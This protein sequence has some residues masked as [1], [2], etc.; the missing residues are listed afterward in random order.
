MLKSLRSEKIIIKHSI[1]GRLRVKVPALKESA[2]YRQNWLS[3]CEK[4][5]GMGEVRSNMRCLSTVLLYDTTVLNAEELFSELERILTGIMDGVDLKTSEE[6]SS[7]RSLEENSSESWRFGALSILAAGAFVCKTIFKM[8]LGES[9]FTPLGAAVALFTLPL[10]SKAVKDTIDK[11]RINLHTFLGGSCLLAVFMGEALTALEILWITEGADLLKRIITEKSRS[12]IRNILEVAENEVFILKDG[13]EVAVTSSSLEVGEIIVLHTGEKIPVDATVVSGRALVNESAIT[14]NSLQVEK[15]EGDKIL[16][17]TIVEEGLLRAEITAVGAD[18]Y[19]SYIL[20]QV[21][22][23]LGNKAEIELIAD[24]LA[25]NLVYIGF[26]ATGLTYLFTASVVRAMTVMLIMACPCATVLAASSAITAALRSAAKRGILIKGGRYLEVVADTSVYCFD[27][28]GTLTSSD[29]ELSRIIAFNDFAE[30]DI[31]GF[32]LSAE[33][34]N[35]HPLARAIRHETSKRGIK[36]HQHAECDFVHGK[37]VRAVVE[38]DVICVGSYIFMEE[39]GVYVL[40]HK[41]EGEELSRHGMMVVY[42]AFNYQ[43]AGII[44]FENCLRPELHET[45]LRLRECGVEH[46]HMLTG[47]SKFAAEHIAQ[48]YNFDCCQHSLLPHQKYEIV[49]SLQEDGFTVV[50]VGDGINDGLALVQ[51]DVG[52]AMGVGGT[53]VALEAADIVLI[54]D[55][56]EDLYGLRVISRKTTDI[57]KQNFMLATG[58]NIIGTIM[59]AAGYIN[60]FMAGLLHIGHTL[61][62]LANSSRLLR[63]PETRADFESK[64]SKGNLDNSEVVYLD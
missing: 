9:L 38:D 12:S 58:T 43:L 51:A 40:P 22:D 14:G 18:T 64:P 16:S 1:S 39:S 7:H 28:T 34:H 23:N 35:Q 57:V 30:D 15:K 53:D 49:K 24:K 25:Q 5:E 10:V 48:R 54:N 3:M 31:L 29:P 44:G 11:K 26:G 21:E 4:I 32:A 17:G 8:V 41:S 2:V 47:D 55:G 20:R 46:L 63:F 45:L 60:P 19:L 61:G 52:I 27:K 37:G 59:A 56:L 50:M 42:V 6:Q 33:L 13:V 36:R 62:I